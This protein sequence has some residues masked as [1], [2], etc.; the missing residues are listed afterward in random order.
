MA[1]SVPQRRAKSRRHSRK[2]VDLYSYEAHS[3]VSLLLDVASQ[4]LP[5]RTATLGSETALAKAKDVRI[6]SSIVIS[7]IERFQVARHVDGI[8]VDRRLIRRNRH[9]EL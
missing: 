8:V 9:H 1:G 6:T 2:T 7:V 5:E 4:P 3:L